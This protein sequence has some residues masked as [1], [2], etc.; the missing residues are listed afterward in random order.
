MAAAAAA[1]FLLYPG[2]LLSS[3][4]MVMNLHFFQLTIFLCSLLATLY[5]LRR[6]SQTLLWTVLALLG[7]LLN[8]ALSE[9]WFF[10]ELV[11]PALIWFELAS[12]EAGLQTAHPANPGAQPAFP[13][14]FCRLFAG[15]LASIL[16][17][18][19]PVTDS[20]LSTTLKVIR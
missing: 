1:L 13:G 12:Q 4:A 5:A 6:P 9:Y 8:L 10:L 11:R 2:F 3:I 14:R 18:S 19:T 15:P 20:H 16:A 7:A 17:G